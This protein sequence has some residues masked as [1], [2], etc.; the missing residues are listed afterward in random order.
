VMNGHEII[1]SIDEQ[2]QVI[3]R[4]AAGEMEREEF[5][6]WLRSHMMEL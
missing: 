3:L 6:E 4:L 5:T 1:A 2:E